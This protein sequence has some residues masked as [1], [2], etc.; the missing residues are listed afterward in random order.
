ME[1]KG[2][3]M[4]GPQQQRKILRIG[5]IQGGRITEERLIRRGQTV[6]I[7]DGAKNTFVLHSSGLPSRF[8]LFV[9]RGNQYSLAFSKDMDGKLSMDGGVVMGFDGVK[10]KATRQKDGSFLFPLNEKIR[11]KV[12]I[13]GTTILFQ[14]VPPPPPPAKGVQRDLG[15]SIIRQIDHT[16]WGIFAMSAILHAAIM[17]YSMSL[18]PPKELTL[19]EIPNRFAKFIVPQRELKSVDADAEADAKKKAEDDAKKKAEEEAKKKAEEKEKK[20]TE[21]SELED[22]KPPPKKSAAEVRAEKKEKLK[23]VGILKVLGSRMGK[24]GS[25][26]GAMISSITDTPGLETLMNSKAKGFVVAGSG[27]TGLK[28]DAD[29]TKLDDVGDV[30]STRMEKEV[31]TAKRKAIKPK[32][33][34]LEPDVEG[35]GDRG[36]L[37]GVIK[38]NLPGV[39]ACYEQALKLNPK[40]RGKIYIEFTV[41]ESGRVSRV[42]L[43]ATSTLDPGMEKCIRRRVIRWRFPSSEEGPA[44]VSLP[45]VLTATQ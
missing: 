40:L 16:Y 22:R 32:I 35:G 27:G 41:A 6:T 2:F 9:Y 8:P 38:R 28:G 34:S 33:E 37:G 13:A 12:T 7:G 26:V 15:G 42:E 1:K 39:R 36:S 31:S 10:A 30:G 29:D 14:F 45:I 25:G 21:V 43:R 11:G 20:I 4:G 44:D 17:M 5:I 23:K 3:V 19:E 24:S 18:P